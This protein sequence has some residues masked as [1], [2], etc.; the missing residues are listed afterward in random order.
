MSVI[1]FVGLV[2]RMA[3]TATTVPQPAATSS[4]D[5]GQFSATAGSLSFASQPVTTSRGS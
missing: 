5:R 3:L 2:D 1:A 4:D